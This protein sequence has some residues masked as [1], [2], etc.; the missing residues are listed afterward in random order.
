MSSQHH[1]NLA[2]VWIHL[3][4]RIAIS[5]ILREVIGQHALHDVFE[6]DELQTE[7][8]LWVKTI[9]DLQRCYLCGVTTGLSDILS[10]S[11]S[12][13]LPPDLLLSSI[14][15]LIS[16][17]GKSFSSQTTL[18]TNTFM[19]PRLILAQTILSGLRLLL[20]YKDH[21]SPNQRRCLQA[22]LNEAWRHDQLQGT[23]RC[24]VQDVY[25]AMLDVMGEPDHRDAYQLERENARLPTY[26]S[27]LVSLFSLHQEHN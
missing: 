19:R 23:E 7:T 24:I 25:V 21:L 20:L 2:A 27:G 6:A 11:S 3:Q 10:L 12:H 5:S 9:Y 26:A 1:K 13:L 17:K 16:I 4:D 15:Y 18:L 14:L 22:A 8:I